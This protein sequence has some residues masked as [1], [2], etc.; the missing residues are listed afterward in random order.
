MSLN[1]PLPSTVVDL[2]IL[3]RLFEEHRPKLLKMVRQRMDPALTRHID[4]E[5]VVNEAFLAARR[6][7]P[8]FKERSAASPYAWLYRIVYGCLID[9]WRRHN[10]RKGQGGP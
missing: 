6:R 2:A 3:G 1:D 9:A 5:D 8:H 10:R 4:A 7:W